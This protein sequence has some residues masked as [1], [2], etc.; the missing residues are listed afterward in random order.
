M[1]SESDKV[2]IDEADYGTLYQNIKEVYHLSLKGKEIYGGWRKVFR[3]DQAVSKI[4]Q[5]MMGS[6]EV[7]DFIHQMRV[8]YKISNESAE[9]LANISLEELSNLTIDDITNKYNYYSFAVEKLKS[10]VEYQTK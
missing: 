9:A 5:M 3:T 6:R 8:Q 10:L 2:Y 7:E 4:I 1:H